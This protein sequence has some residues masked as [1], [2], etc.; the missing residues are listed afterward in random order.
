MQPTSSN[1]FHF[2]CSRLQSFRYDTPSGFNATTNSL[3]ALLVA[4]LD[5]GVS[6]NADVTT[7]AAVGAVEKICTPDD[8]NVLLR[9]T[10][11]VTVTV[12]AYMARFS[13]GKLA[14]AMPV[15][16]TAEHA[17]VSTGVSAIPK[18]SCTLLTPV[19]RSLKPPHVAAKELGPNCR[20]PG[21]TA[22]V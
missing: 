1:G 21:R 16:G 19:P 14:T 7:K 10:R 11:S 9:P 8:V 15:F 17:C 18:Q 20:M 22:S 3:V 6:P 12:A 2:T 5:T 4:L 13:S